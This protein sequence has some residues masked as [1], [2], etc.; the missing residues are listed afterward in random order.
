MRRAE[1]NDLALKK[2]PIRRL[3]S[4]LA[5]GAGIVALAIGGLSLPWLRSPPAAPPTLVM[6]GRGEGPLHAGA[7]SVSI[8]LPPDVPIGGYARLSWRSEGTRDPVGARALVLEVPGCR[9]ALV[10]ADV[11]LLSERLVREVEA[12]V[13]DLRL[14]AVIVGAT[15]THAGPGGFRDEFAFERAALGPFDAGLLD[16]IADRMAQ[17]IRLAAATAVPARMTIARGAANDLVKAR[18]GGREDGRMTAL[19]FEAGS[20][21][22]PIGELLVFPAH[23]TI[24]GKANRRLSG[25]WPG[26]LAARP[27]RGVRLVLQGAIGDQS[28]RMEG[29]DDADAPERYAK[30]VEQ[31]A[32]TLPSAPSTSRTVMATASASV[33]LPAP[34]P[35]A[36]PRLLRRAVSTLARSQLPESARVTVLRL[37]ALR[38]V[39]LPAEPTAAVAQRWRSLVGEDAEIVS[40]V[41]GYAGYVETPE[42]TLRGEGEAVHTY[43][44]PELAARLESAI[45]A[46]SS[47]VAR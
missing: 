33:T 24:L 34:W 22:G 27:G 4:G 1:Y 17:A 46:A 35:G 29:V 28:V 5:I 39:A 30:A 40:L 10:S 36:S 6:G 21:G 2:L 41:G 11:L 20:G 43:Y 14:D 8:D 44:G 47:A 31:H 16:R 38:L 3:F 23:P 13:A 9:A 7:A 45:V 32:D 19:R 26:A 42:R 12:R 25:D 15:H 18:H 37:G